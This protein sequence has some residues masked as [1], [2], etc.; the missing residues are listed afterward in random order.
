YTSKGLKKFLKDMVETDVEVLGSTENFER[1]YHLGSFCISISCQILQNKKLKSYWRKYK[2]TDIRPVVIRRGEMGLTKA[3]KKCISSDLNYQALL[4]VSHFLKS[5]EAN[6]SII[7]FYLQNQRSSERITT[8]KKV[9]AKSIV[10]LISKKYLFDHNKESK[11]G[12]MISEIDHKLFDAYYLNTVDDIMVFLKSITSDKTCPDRDLVKNIIVAELG[13]AFISGSQVHQNAPILLN[14]GLPFVK[15]DGQYRGAFNQE[16]I[17]NITRQ[18]NKI[19]AGELQ[20]LLSNR[21]YGGTT[22][23]SW[24]LTAFMRGLI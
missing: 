17:Y 9:S 14:I 4:N 13:E 5:V 16:D 20:Y 2:L 15:L 8:W 1:S 21:P 18:L 6:P 12:F 7:D 22:L 24:K 10:N 3:L 11:N 19:E 23:V